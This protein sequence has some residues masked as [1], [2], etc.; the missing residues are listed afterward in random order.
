MTDQYF[1]QP[2]EETR[3][4]KRKRHAWEYTLMC[5]AQPP[6]YQRTRSGVVDSL[7]AS[8][9]GPTRAARR[10]FG[11]ADKATEYLRK[12]REE[13]TRYPLPVEIHLGWMGHQKV[14]L[15]K[16]PGDYPRLPEYFAPGQVTDV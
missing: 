1:D 6:R 2:E 9:R 12:K 10:R 14:R 8:W 4:D 16:G 7:A 3:R 5:P 11:S 15:T 13:P